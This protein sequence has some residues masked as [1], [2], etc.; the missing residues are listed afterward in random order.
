[1]V[2]Y[3]FQFAEQRSFDP[4]RG[5]EVTPGLNCQSDTEIDAFVREQVETGY[6]PV[7]TCRMGSPES[8]DRV[9]VDTSC[10]VVGVEGLRVVDASVMPSVVSGNT[11][12]PTIMIADKCSD[13]ILGKPPLPKAKVATLG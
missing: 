5:K 4:Y 10:R 2:C 1:M 6:H 11:N 12:A 9:V 7:G 8:D 3:F 13:M